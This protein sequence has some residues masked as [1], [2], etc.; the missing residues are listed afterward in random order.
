MVQRTAGNHWLQRHA[1]QEFHGYEG[2]AVLLANVVNRA[3][4]G[5]VQCG[6]GL[7][8]ALKTG[9]CLRVTGN[10]LGQELEG[11]EAMQPRVLSLVNHTH[12]ATTHLLNDAVVRDGLADHWRESYVCETGKS[13]KAVELAVSQKDCWRNIA[14]TVRRDKPA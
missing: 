13:M 14:I 6:C 7:G 9:E 11:D 12:P 8:F 10:L 1:I 5:M 3:D 4:V 2:T